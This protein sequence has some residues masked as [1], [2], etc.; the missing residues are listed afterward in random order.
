MEVLVFF[1][2]SPV[3]GEGDGGARRKP[4][5]LSTKSGGR[6]SGFLHACPAM[7]G[8]PNMR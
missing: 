4:R 5:G 2:T 3:R 7:A 1:F 8:R 6:S